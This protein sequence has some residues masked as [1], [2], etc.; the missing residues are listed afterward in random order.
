MLAL[1]YSKQMDKVISVACWLENMGSK[2]GAI[3]HFRPVVT[4]SNFQEM[5]KVWIFV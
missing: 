3:P 1:A 4:S 2:V 5:L